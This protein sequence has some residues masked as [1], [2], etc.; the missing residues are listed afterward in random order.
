MYID[1]A[2]I[3]AGGLGTRLLPT[4]KETPK[5]ML[6]VYDVSDDNDIYLKP[7]VQK[8]F[9]NLYSIG[10]RNFCFVVSRG[11]RAIEDY[12]TPDNSYLSL[13]VSRKLD[14]KVKELKSFYNKIYDS[15][16]FFINQPE[17][18]GF[19]DAVLRA[20]SFV[21]YSNFIVHAGDD[22]ILSKDNSYLKKLIGVFHKYN[23]E[24]TLLVEEIEDPRK[25]GVIVPKPLSS[26]KDVYRI[27]D[28]IEKPEVPP[29]NYAVIG[30][31]VFTPKIFS[32]LKRIKPD[33]R[34]ELQLTDAIRELVKE[35]Y[36]AYAVKLGEN[37]RRVD[38]GTPQSYYNALEATYKFSLSL[39]GEKCD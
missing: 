34:G 15:R 10:I 13:L 7:I 37:E 20:E 11:K 8:V 29:S 18:K 1:K 16:I 3:T 32:A 22:I 27:M 21:G 23:S 25:Y 5:E 19:G 12:F 24:V 30:I 38:I 28:I 14:K 2:V 6:P 33:S 36:N 35:G 26:E 9:E 4:T 17:P 39:K 31:Y